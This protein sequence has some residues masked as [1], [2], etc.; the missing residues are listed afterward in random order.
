VKFDSLASERIRIIKESAL[1]VIQVG[2]GPARN[3]L[4]G[5][6]DSVE[7]C[8]RTASSLEAAPFLLKAAQLLARTGNCK[9]AARL[10][11][12]SFALWREST[13]SP[14]ESEWRQ[15]G[16]LVRALATALGARATQK[17]LAAGAEMSLAGALDLMRKVA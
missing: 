14:G 4:P 9:P 12:L 2:S 11:G 6:I 3:P 13:Y 5:L 7:D 10:A 1:A 17:A 15:C 8:Q 16:R